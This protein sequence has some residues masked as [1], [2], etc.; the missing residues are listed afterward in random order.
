MSPGNP[1]PETPGAASH[2]DA[3]IRSLLWQLLRLVAAEVARQLRRP[4]GDEPL[5][6]DG[7]P[8]HPHP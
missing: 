8:E 3:E 5:R 2:A 7:D 4:T 1:T 6:E